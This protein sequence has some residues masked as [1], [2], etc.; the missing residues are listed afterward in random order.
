MA[1]KVKKKRDFSKA[2]LIAKVSVFWILVAGVIVLVQQ[3]DKAAYTRGMSDG[4]N[5]A[6]TTIRSK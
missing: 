6:A 4:Y 5:S 2:I 3:T 1:D